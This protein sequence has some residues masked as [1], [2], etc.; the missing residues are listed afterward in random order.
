MTWVTAIDQFVE[1]YTLVIDNDRDA[2]NDQIAT[3]QG[4][5]GDRVAYVNYLRSQWEDY[6]D[7]VAKKCATMWGDSS[8]AVLL[9]RQMM[10]GWGDTPW[11]QIADHYIELAK[12]ARSA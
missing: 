8:P 5:N 1:D 7:Q 9:I 4:F 2:Y 10:N 12:E 11:Y 6:V 3:A